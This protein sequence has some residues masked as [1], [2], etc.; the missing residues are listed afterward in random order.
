M[1]I[2]KIISSSPSR[3]DVLMNFLNLRSA[4]EVFSKAEL[5]KE[6]NLSL[7]DGGATRSILSRLPREKVAFQGSVMWVYGNEA[8]II[9][10]RNQLKGTDEN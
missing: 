1:K 6:T 5:E 4:D 8:A 10:L 9:N 7:P 2:E 3:F